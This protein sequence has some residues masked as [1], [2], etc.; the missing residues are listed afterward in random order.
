MRFM[1][2]YDIE[3]AFN[4]FDESVTPNRFA[5]IKVVSRLADWANRN[6]DGWHSWPKPCRAASVAMSHIE[7]RT[8]R[9]N[10]EQE[11]VDISDAERVRALTPIKAFLTRQGA[12]D[13]DKREILFGLGPDETFVVEH[14][15]II[16]VS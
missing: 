11:D 10:N 7:S 9:E 5:L 3:H 6:S 16:H 2:D 12:S 14:F 8:S 15:A 1:N 4:R 13:A